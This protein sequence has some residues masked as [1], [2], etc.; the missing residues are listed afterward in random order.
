[1]NNRL[2]A[3]ILWGAAL[4]G[5]AALASTRHSPAVYASDTRDG[6]MIV[7]P[8]GAITCDCTQTAK[9]CICKITMD[10]E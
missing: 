8:S 5:A 1:M 6:K 7:S 4:L 3:A 10:N 2:A 9:E